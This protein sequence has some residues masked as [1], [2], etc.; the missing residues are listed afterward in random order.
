MASTMASGANE[1]SLQVEERSLP[2][3]RL[4]S[5]DRQHWFGYYDKWQVDPSG[6]YA[7]GN[8]VELFFRSPQPNDVLK[9]GLIDLEGGDA[10]REMGES[11]AWGWQQGC[12]LQWIPGSSE[13][14][15][16]ND[17]GADGQFVCRIF[18][19]RTKERRELP[20]AIYTLS[21]DGSYGLSVDFG[22][23]QY[24]RPGYG[25]AVAKGVA[26]EEHERAPEDNGIFRVDL[27]TGES[28]L[29]LSLA[30]IAAYGG[31]SSIRR[32]RVGGVRCTR[33]ISGGLWSEGDE[34]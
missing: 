22:R 33:W 28:E 15:M 21:P 26:A 20:R 24:F 1:K 17:V 3:R 2:V 6:R 4:T 25:Y 34:V 11:R 16:W 10:W 32:T 31:C 19:I 30:Q 12:M 13:E 29:I 7:L 23:L 18:S 5:G 9:V 27:R 14:V 8:Q